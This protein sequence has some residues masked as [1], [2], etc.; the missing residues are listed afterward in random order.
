MPALCNV[1]LTDGPHR[2]AEQVFLMHNRNDL[3]IGRFPNGY[4]VVFDAL[5]KT[6]CPPSANPLATSAK[7]L[8]AAID[9]WHRFYEAQY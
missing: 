8:T 4:Y 5:T 1:W 6:F 7:T 9:K 2:W 3:D